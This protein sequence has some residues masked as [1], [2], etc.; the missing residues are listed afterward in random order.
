MRPTSPPPPGPGRRL[1]LVVQSRTHRIVFAA[2][3]YGG[4]EIFH[5]LHPLFLGR[6]GVYLIVFNMERMVGTEAQRAACLKDLRF[7]L[8]SVAVHGAGAPVLLVGTHKDKV[9][10]SEFF[11]SVLFL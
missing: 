5:C 4:Q 7:W 6:Y 1:D 11:H 10:S 2:W 3:D 9:C 8:S